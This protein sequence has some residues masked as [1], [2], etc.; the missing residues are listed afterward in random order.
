MEIHI[1]VPVYEPGHLGELRLKRFV[2]QRPL[3]ELEADE[4]FLP[5]T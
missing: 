5:S 3:V 4:Q 2:R 1:G